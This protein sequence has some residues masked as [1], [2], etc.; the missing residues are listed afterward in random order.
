MEDTLSIIFAIL[1]AL[2]LMFLFPLVDSWDLQ[3]NLSYAIA[4][5]ATVDFVDTARN[6]GYISSDL[7]DTFQNKLLATG[8]TYDITLE[9]REFNED[10]KAYLS[11][12][13]NEIEKDL[14]DSSKSHI[15]KLDKYDYFYVTVKNTNRTQATVINDFFS[16]SHGTN[17]KIAVAYGGVVWSVRDEF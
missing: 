12:Y 11:V 8:N 3:D 16:S 15:H 2:I 6:T 9:H 5:S 1:I 4:Y 10:L 7:Y 14:A 17:T 13:T